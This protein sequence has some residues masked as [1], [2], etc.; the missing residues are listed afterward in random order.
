[1]LFTIHFEMTT[2]EGM[3]RVGKL[4]VC[5]LAGSER[6]SKSGAHVAGVGA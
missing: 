6:L 4:H 5:D 3:K 1:M 2:K